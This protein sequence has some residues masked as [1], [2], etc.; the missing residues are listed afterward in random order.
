MS[1]FLKN[2]NLFGTITTALPYVQSIVLEFYANLEKYMYAEGFP[3]YGQVYVRGQIIS[4][5]PEAINEFCGTPNIQDIDVFNDLGELVKEITGGR[6][7]KWFAYPKL[8]FAALTSLYIVLHKL[9]VTNWLSS[10]NTSIVTQ[11]QAKILFQIGTGFSFS[12]GKWVFDSVTSFV[13]STAES[14]SFPFPYLVYSF[15]SS[16]E[17]EK[18]EAERFSKLPKPIDIAKK[19]LRGDRIIDLPLQDPSPQTVAAMEGSSP[20]PPRV[21]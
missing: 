12:F 7:L 14:W 21:S 9:C 16:H 5:T 17:V 11:P 18:L 15:L 1:K 10:S 2:R 13:E 20:S 8:L 6:L 4:F 19:V 3:R